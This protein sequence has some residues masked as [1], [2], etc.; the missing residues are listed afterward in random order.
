MNKDW[1]SYLRVKAALEHKEAD[2]IPFDVGGT[3]LTGIHRKAYANLRRHLGLN[4]DENNIALDNIPQQLAVVEEDVRRILKCDVKSVMPNPSS[5][6]CV[7]EPI[8]IDGGDYKFTDEWGIGRRMPVDGGIYYDMYKAPLADA[9]DCNDLKKFPWPDLTEP[10][11]FSGMKERADMTVYGEK[12]AY[13]LGRSYAGIFETALWMRGFEN[14]LCDM[15]AEPEFAEALMDIIL[16][17]KMQYWG[18][19]LDT[20][21]ENVMIIS[22]A[23]D[24]GTQNSLIVSKEMYRRLIKPRHKK[25]V[26]FIKQRAQNKVYIFFHCCG[27]ISEIL[28]DIIESGIDILNPWQVNARDMDTKEF[29]KNFGRDITIWGGGCDTQRILPYG[30]PRQVRDE[31]RRRIEDLAPGGGF[32]FNPVHNIQADV[33]PENVM[34]MWETW[35]EYSRYI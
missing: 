29:K 6:S 8:H 3:V 31:V 7:I 20:V 22:E 17:L 2:R 18:K 1:N 33:P 34:A 10:L 14:F 21:G 23:D 9:M 27:A 4:V 35:N 26:E 13:V 15:A 19:A 30:T 28:P 24:L 12:T 5:T 11:R 32:I 16:E 25:L